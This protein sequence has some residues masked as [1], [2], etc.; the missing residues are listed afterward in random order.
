M[1]DKKTVKVDIYGIKRKFRNF[2]IGVM[3]NTLIQDRAMLEL[4][5]EKWRQKQIPVAKNSVQ[6]FIVFLRQNDLWDDDKVRT[7]CREKEFSS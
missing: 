2:D 7:W 5:F 4:E 3:N 1:D 6:S